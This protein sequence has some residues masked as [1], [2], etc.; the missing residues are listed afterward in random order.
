LHWFFEIGFT[1]SASGNITQNTHTHIY[2]LLE[3]R[4]RLAIW[5]ACATYSNESRPL[6]QINDRPDVAALTATKDEQTT[7]NKA[8]KASSLA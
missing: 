2:I 1:P 5:L 3:V 4:V 8:V 6:G 7:A